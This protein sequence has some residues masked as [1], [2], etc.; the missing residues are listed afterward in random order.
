MT[1]GC[2]TSS[3]GWH[4]HVKW[5]H[6]II[7]VCKTCE[8]LN[9]WISFLFSKWR[10]IYDKK[11]YILQQLATFFYLNNVTSCSKCSFSFIQPFIHFC[12]APHR[13][14]IQNIP[15]EVLTFSRFASL[16]Q[17]P[18]VQRCVGIPGSCYRDSRGAVLCVRLGWGLHSSDDTGLDNV[19]VSTPTD[20]HT[21]PE[22]AITVEPPSPYCSLTYGGN[23][24]T[25]QVEE[26]SGSDF[27][28]MHPWGC[29]QS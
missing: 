12:A 4:N 3:L 29:Y 7:T 9:F 1:E 10:N 26:S 11:C 23:Y 6:M 19:S 22:E 20:T 13:V 18:L 15:F 24:R 2:A 28:T 5:N 17:R 16:G 8:L 21:R 27:W 14:M 25:Y